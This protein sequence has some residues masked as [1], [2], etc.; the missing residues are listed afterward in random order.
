MEYKGFLSVENSFEEEFCEDLPIP[1][2]GVA[3]EH[4]QEVPGGEELAQLLAMSM[5]EEDVSAEG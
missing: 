3:P 2:N 4:I 1:S 5:E